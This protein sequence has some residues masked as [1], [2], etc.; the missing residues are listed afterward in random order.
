MHVAWAQTIT[1]EIA[2]NWVGPLAASPRHPDFLLNI[3]DR[4]TWCTKYNFAIT[5]CQSIARVQLADT[6]YHHVFCTHGVHK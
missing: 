5:S 3:S 2:L 1:T 4:L 6:L